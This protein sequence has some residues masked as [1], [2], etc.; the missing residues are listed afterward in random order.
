MVEELRLTIFEFKV[1]ILDP[2]LLISAK[3]EVKVLFVDAVNNDKLVL[4]FVIKANC[5]VKV[6][7]IFETDVFNVEI[8]VVWLFYV[9]SW[10]ANVEF[11]ALVNNDKFVLVV[12][13]KF[14]CDVRVE[15][16]FDTEAT[17]TAS[18]VLTFV[19]KLDKPVEFVYINPR[20]DVSVV[21]VFAIT[22]LSALCVAIDIG[23][24]KSD[25]LSTFPR[26]ICP[27]DT[28]PTVP[29][30]VG[31]FTGAIVPPMVSVCELPSG[32]TKE[33]ELA[34]TST[35]LVILEDPFLL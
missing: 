19:F 12:L 31:L 28:P 2:L 13:I 21:F 17:T 3:C 29:V 30:K 10:A 5:D 16:I 14:N 34:M 8:L 11:V 1:D 9:A 22:V 20:W 23:L 35:A 25:V 24:F 18:L 32:W 33:I 4:V 27:L 6:E 7:L 26:P 15:L